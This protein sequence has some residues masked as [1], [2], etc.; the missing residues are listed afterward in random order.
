MSIVQCAC[1]GWIWYRCFVSLR[2]QRAWLLKLLAVELHAGDVSSSNHREACQTIL[3]YLFSHGIKD[4]GGG[5][6]MYP[7]LHHDTSQNAALGTVSKSKV[8]IVTCFIVP[9]ILCANISH[10]M[11][12][13]D[14]LLFIT[15]RLILWANISVNFIVGFFSFCDRLIRL[16]FLLLVDV[17]NHIDK[18]VKFNYVNYGI[19]WEELWELNGEWA[20]QN[21]G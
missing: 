21:R 3:S 10:H 20:G 14:S 17:G 11:H 18:F 19:T 16:F 1:K 15:I 13:L 7:F 2:S 12:V 9:L 8:L 4:I 5:Q 6:A